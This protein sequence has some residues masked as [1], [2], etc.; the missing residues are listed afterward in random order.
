MEVLKVI[1]ERRSIRSC[2][3]GAFNEKKVSE[4]LNIPQNFHPI[5]IVPVGCPAE[6]P[7]TS[8]RVSKEEA[9]EFL[10]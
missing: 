8:T 9:V 3:V 7:K 2:P 1:K 4:I 10:K 6:K 5:L